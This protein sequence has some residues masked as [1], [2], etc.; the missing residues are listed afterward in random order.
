M[1]LLVSMKTRA[2]PPNDPSCDFLG[3][4]TIPGL[5]VWRQGGQSGGGSGCIMHCQ[6]YM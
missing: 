6:L 4:H 3:E 1:H 2:N 5:G